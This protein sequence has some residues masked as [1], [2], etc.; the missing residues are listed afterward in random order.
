M[1]TLIVVLFIGAK[2]VVNKT[3]YPT[4]AACEEA[5]YIEIDKPGVFTVTC[6]GVGE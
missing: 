6:L 2:Y 5:M 4:M 3:P 1:A